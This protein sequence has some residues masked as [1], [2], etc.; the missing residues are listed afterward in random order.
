MC[1]YLEKR[2][3][4]VHDSENKRAW[5]GAT[6][7]DDMKRGGGGLQL[8]KSLHWVSHFENMWFEGVAMFLKRGLRDSAKMGML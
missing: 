8:Y 7:M 4:P 6:R 1:L 5:L 3:I 2:D